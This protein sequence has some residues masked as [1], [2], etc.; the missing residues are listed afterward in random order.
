MTTRKKISAREE[1]MV[2]KIILISCQK[3]LLK[4][5]VVTEIA[6]TLSRNPSQDWR[7]NLNLMPY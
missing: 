6:G 3:D 7:Q 4:S 1:M 5:N 2:I